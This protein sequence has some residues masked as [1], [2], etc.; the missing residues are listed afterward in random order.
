M[1]SG[2]AVFDK[3]LGIYGYGNMTF[4][5]IY[6]YEEGAIVREVLRRIEG[7]LGLKYTDV[8]EK[9]QI[10]KITHSQ[11]VESGT[12]VLAVLQ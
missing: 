12:P 11:D 6:T 5:V 3:D 8:M 2:W 4:E 1:S 10:E 9:R 7:F